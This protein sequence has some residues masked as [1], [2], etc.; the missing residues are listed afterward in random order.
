MIHFAMPDEKTRLAIWKK[1]FPKETKTGEIDY[2]YLARQFPLS[3]GNIKNIILS[4]AFYAAGRQESVGMEHIL[5]AVRDE[6]AKYDK[7]MED[8]EFGEYGYMF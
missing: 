6:Y 5:T 3:G 2:H 8:H 4:A 1:G 7:K